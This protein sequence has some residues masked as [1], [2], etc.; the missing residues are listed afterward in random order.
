MPKTPMLKKTKPKN[1]KPRAATPKAAGT[2][3]PKPRAAKPTG[4]RAKSQ[5]AEA[6][7]IKAS[8]ATKASTPRKPKLL[9]VA[10]LAELEP[11]AEARNE[12]LEIVMI[13]V[14]AAKEK[15]ARKMHLLE[16]KGVADFTDYFL[17]CSGTNPRQVQAICDEIDASMRRAGLRPAHIEGYNHAEWV[18]LDYV[19]FVAHVFTEQAREYYDLER[20]WRMARR[21]P[22][23]EE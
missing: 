7:S 18:L 3:P 1:T 20:L 11:V 17:V 14:E 12:S 23:G 10:S 2:K 6:P 16:L 8:K 5:S 13:A 15:Q 9:P 21:I 4:L 19:D 22:V